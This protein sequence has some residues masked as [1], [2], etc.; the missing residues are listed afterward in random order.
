M[1]E[2]T[3]SSAVAIFG[4]AGRFPGAA[5]PDAF[6]RNLCSGHEAI[7]FFDAPA[8]PPESALIH[9]AASGHLNGVALFDA[10]F[11]NISPR[12]AE[13]MDPQHRVF[14]ECAWEA[15]ERAGYADRQG[16]W[17]RRCICRRR[18]QS[19]RGTHGRLRTGAFRHSDCQ[20]P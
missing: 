10:D 8:A 4:M 14:L 2:P 9:V 7:T 15:L 11:F 12:D 18:Q 20:R 1:S 17:P 16:R 13:I 6:W 5:D 3:S 19:L